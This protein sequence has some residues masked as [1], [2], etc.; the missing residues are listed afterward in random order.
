LV[1]Q[2]VMT[3]QQVINNFGMR[4]TVWEY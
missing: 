4:I 2:F 3:I 1:I